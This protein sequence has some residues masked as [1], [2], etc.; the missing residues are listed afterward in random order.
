MADKENWGGARKGAGRK[1]GQRKDRDKVARQLTL[2]P[3]LWAEIDQAQ[4]DLGLTR[5]S[6]FEQMA[7]AW[8][9]NLSRESDR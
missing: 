9:D 7:R 6:I 8:L 5:A 3:A 1:A 4:V 2:P